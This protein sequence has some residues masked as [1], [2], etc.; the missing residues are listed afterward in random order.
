MTVAELLPIFAG[1]LGGLILLLAAVIGWLFQR[2]WSML[3]QIFALLRDLEKD[4]RG[5]LLQLERRVSALEGKCS[6]CRRE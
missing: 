6:T 1:M 3:G 5:D 4:M 2:V